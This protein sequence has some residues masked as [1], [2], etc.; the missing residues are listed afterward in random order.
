MGA[1]RGRRVG[2]AARTR[3]HAGRSSPHSVAARRPAVDADI[4]ST[5]TDSKVL[6]MD[7]LRI[8]IDYG[9]LYDKL[10]ARAV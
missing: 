2:Q 8:L 9:N 5:S 3:Q 4:R 7:L 10:R 6:Q 1:D